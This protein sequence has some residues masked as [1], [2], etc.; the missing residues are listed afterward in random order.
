MLVAAMPNFFD[1]FG[2]DMG[3]GFEQLEAC[4]EYQAG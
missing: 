2:V 3:S 1:I 4:P